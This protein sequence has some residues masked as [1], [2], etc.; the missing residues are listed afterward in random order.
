MTFNAFIILSVLYRTLNLRIIPAAISILVLDFVLNVSYIKGNTQSFLLALSQISV[1]MVITYFLASEHDKDLNK[2]AKYATSYFYS[3]PLPI[4]L[5]DKNDTIKYLNEEGTFL[6]NYYKDLHKDSIEKFLMIFKESNKTN[7]TLKYYL[8]KFHKLQSLNGKKNIKTF[9][10]S[11]P[12][13]TSI[14]GHSFEFKYYSILLVPLENS[15]TIMYFKDISDK[16]YL[17][18]HMVIDKKKS[19]LISTMSHELRTPLNGIIGVLYVI[20]EKLPLGLKGLWG[21]AYTSAQLLL[22]TVNCML[23]FSCLE[24]DKL[25]LHNRNMNIRAMF[26]ELIKLFSC[27][28][29]KD[30]VTLNQIIADNVPKAFKT[31]SIRIKQVLMNLLSNAVNYTYTGTVTLLAVMDEPHTMKIIVK[32]TGIGISEDAQKNIFNLFGTIN[33]MPSLYDC[34]LPGL[35]LTVSNKLINML[36]GSMNLKSALDTGSI[37]TFTE[38]KPQLSAVLFSLEFAK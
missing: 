4:I 32:D 37:F 38:R 20:S 13:D 1:L 28:V 2:L 23:D 36:G 34:K 6:I 9:S 22:N 8:E 26:S 19:L 16:E 31:D 10:I 11:N 35:G 14:N 12:Q 24:I 30:R 5:F 21:T 18:E 7:I 29:S 27:L 25:T 17:K 3:L 33:N 15:E